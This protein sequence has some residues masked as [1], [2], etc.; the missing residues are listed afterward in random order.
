[1]RSH[2]LA[3]WLFEF[4][5]ILFNFC[6]KAHSNIKQYYQVFKCR[7]YD[8]KVLKLGYLS[9]LT[10]MYYCVYDI[11]HPKYLIYYRILS[12]L[13]YDIHLLNYDDIKRSQ[14]N[15]CI[16]VTRLVKDN[17]VHNIIT[18][19]SI[20]GYFEKSITC[21]PVLYCTLNDNIDLTHIVSDFLPSL[22][23]NDSGLKCKWYVDALCE[24]AG[25]KRG[26]M[27]GCENVLKYMLDDDKYEEKIFKDNDIILIK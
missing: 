12:Y 16:L 26:I 23:Y 6:D 4:Y 24:F 3:M 9:K 8:N 17:A 21:D 27:K 11:D 14:S 19:K 1:M 7:Y 10:R 22:Y 5:N 25:V 13:G 20:D 2:A 15:D 18:D